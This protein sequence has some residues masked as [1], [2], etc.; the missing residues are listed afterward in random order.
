MHYTVCQNDIH[1][2]FKTLPQN[3]VFSTGMAQGAM[4][5]KMPN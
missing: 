1:I 5:H 2:H 4:Q 3:E